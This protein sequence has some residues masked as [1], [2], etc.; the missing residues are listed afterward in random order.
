MSCEFYRNGSRLQMCFF[1]LGL[2]P[3]LVQ[4]VNPFVGRLPNDCSNPERQIRRDKMHESESGEESE[5][6]DDHL[7]VGN[8]I[9]IQSNLSK[10]PPLNSDNLHTTT[11]VVAAVM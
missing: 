1:T 6:F 7:D 8:K 5:T 9:E 11:T 3:V 4:M 2:T 10:R